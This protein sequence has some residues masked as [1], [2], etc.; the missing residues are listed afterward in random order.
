MLLAGLPTVPNGRRVRRLWWDLSRQLF[1]DVLRIVQRLLA[2]RNQKQSVTA[3]LSSGVAILFQ[4]ALFLLVG[5]MLFA[6]YQ[7]PAALFG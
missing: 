7:K 4:F 5:V 6:F 2:A 3:L 1:D